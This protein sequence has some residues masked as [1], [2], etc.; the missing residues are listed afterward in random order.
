MYK[1]MNYEDLVRK[2]IKECLEHG[3]SYE[4]IVFDLLGLAKYYPDAEIIPVLKNLP[5][6]IEEEL[7]KILQFF[8]NSK[9]YYLT[10]NNGTKLISERVRRIQKLNLFKKT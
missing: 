8:S 6:N 1:N 10:C 4:D 7:L 5:K 9:E 3:F 2:H